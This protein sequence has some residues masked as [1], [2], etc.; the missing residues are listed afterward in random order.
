M[1]SVIESRWVGD[2]M[3]KG[4]GASGVEN[5]SASDCRSILA[6]A[7]VI[8][9]R[10]CSTF[11]GE[12]WV[13]N[14]ISSLRDWRARVDRF[15]LIRSCKAS[16]ESLRATALYQPQLRQH[17]GQRERRPGIGGMLHQPVPATGT[18]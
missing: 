2:G 11:F 8:A 1:G 6:R 18:R 10:A 15:L 5:Y 4:S 17:N 12:T 16:D 3:F 9:C 13:R 7:W 14:S